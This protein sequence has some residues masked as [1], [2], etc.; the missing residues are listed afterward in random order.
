[1][2]NKGEPFNGLSGIKV[3]SIE[4]ESWRNSPNIS[5]RPDVAICLDFSGTKILLYGEIKTQ[6]TP[7]ILK[8][9][10]PWLIKFNLSNS[11]N[12]YIL[13][14]PY[15]PLE[16]QKYCQENNVGFID[17]CGN[18]SIGIPGK[19]LIQRLGRPNIFKTPRL[20]RNPFSGVSSRVL[21]VLLNNPGRKW[22]VGDIYQELLKESLEQGRDKY[23]QISLSSVS[24]TID[25]LD[26][27]LLVRRDGMKIAIPEP[28]RLLFKW[29]EKYQERYKWMLRSSWLCKNSFDFDLKT[30]LNGLMLKFP[31]ADF[32]LTGSAAA[33]FTAPFVNIDR[34]DVYVM[35][36]GAYG[37]LRKFAATDE[38]GKGPDFLF[39]S[40]Y[41]KGVAMY[42]NR[43]DSIKTVS[44]IQAYL[45]CYA[46]GGRDAKQAEY[47]LTNIIEKRWMKN[48]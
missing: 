5:A 42:S 13:V 25:S 16:S 7:K 8:E 1:M 43:F 20:L 38:K 29:A 14:C 45:D 47:L 26:E 39:F 28:N 18:I 10:A 6:I 35:N 41:D 22:L 12:L 31:D 15:L 30:S 2:L 4:P 27:A 19:V 11:T 37:E 44:N 32:V 17:M 24:K 23:F 9:I 40:P 36:P 3:I 21:R 34:I 33:N 46:K 48:D